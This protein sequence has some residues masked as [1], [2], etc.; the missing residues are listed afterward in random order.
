[1]VH[2]D[3]V[4]F[5]GQIESHGQTA[6]RRA[7]YRHT[8][9]AGRQAYHFY[10]GLRPLGTLHVTFIPVPV[11]DW[12]LIEAHSADAVYVGQ[13]DA[14]AP[15]LLTSLGSADLDTFA[16]ERS[17]WF[18]GGMEGRTHSRHWQSMQRAASRTPSSRV[19]LTPSAGTDRG[20]GATSRVWVNRAVWKGARIVSSAPCPMA[21]RPLYP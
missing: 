17:G 12:A 16:L 10:F 2:R 15:A 1:M 21:A 4:S 8:F 11:L 18:T 5:P 6:R 9:G 20:T 14:I 7:E 3:G 19:N 13:D